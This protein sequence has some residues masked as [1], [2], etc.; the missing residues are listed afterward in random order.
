MFIY[1]NRTGFNGLYRLNSQGG[2]NV[3]AGRYVNPRICDAPN[4][5]AVAR[6]LASPGV[7]L[8]RDGDES[9]RPAGGVRW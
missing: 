2:S 6:A 7:A 1:L 8:E 3:P 9:A 5:R 4:L